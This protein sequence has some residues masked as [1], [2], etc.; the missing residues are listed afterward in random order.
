MRWACQKF[1][2]FVYGVDFEVCTDHKPL[3]TVLSAKSTPPSARI[4]R[5]LLCLQQFRYVVKHIAGVDNHVEALS[6]LPLDPPQSQDANEIAEYANS[7]AIEAILAAVTALEVERAS[8]QDLTLQLVREAVA[9]GDWGRLSGTMY[10]ALAGEIWVLGQLVLRGNRIILSQSLW[11]RTIK[12]AHEVHQGM[13]RTKARLRQKVWWPHMDK[14]VNEFIRACHPCQLVGPRSKPEPIR[15]TTILEGPWTDI[16]VDL[17][18][19]PGGYHLL[20]AMHNYSHWPEVILLKETDA[21]HVTRTMEGMFQTHGLPVTVRTDNGPPFSSAQFGGFIEYLGITQ[22]KGIPYWPQS[23]SEV[24]RANE[25]LLKIIRI[26]NLQNTDWKKA[27]RDFLFHY[28]TTPHTST[29]L[30]PAELLMGRRLNDKLPTINIPSERLTEAHWQQLLRGR[31]AR[32]KLKQKE[33]ADTKRSAGYIDIV[34]GDCILLNKSRENKLSPNFEP[35]PYKVIQKKGNAVLIE[36]QEG[37]TKMRNASHM[38]KFI[39][40]E[41][42]LET[43]AKDGEIKPQ[44]MPRSEDAEES[45]KTNPDQG[46]APPF[47]ESSGIPSSLRPVRTG[48]PPTSVTWTKDYMCSYTCS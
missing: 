30:S 42:C 31:D 19:I 11:K 13:V 3:I 4:E 33:Y 46:S 32:A 2:L 21:A 28:R 26:A 9:S 16:A 40:P 44:T 39:Q 25:T 34:E 1:Y 38:K 35:A 10:K 24:E 47:E 18:E 23:N 15:S 27:V 20:V 8:S 12:L 17:L 29:G 45:T 37:T 14:Q 36:D 22:K 6:R 43:P 7:G 5:W 41:P 48:R